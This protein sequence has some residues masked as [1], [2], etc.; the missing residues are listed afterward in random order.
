LGRCYSPGGP[1]VLARFG[2]PLLAAEPFAIYQVARA[3][4]TARRL[5]PRRSIAAQ[6]VPAA[7]SSLSKRARRA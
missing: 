3:G 6:R 1:Q 4:W 2:S 7:G 5:R